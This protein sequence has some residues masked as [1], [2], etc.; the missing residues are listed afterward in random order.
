[1]SYLARLLVVV[2]GYLWSYLATCSLIWLPEVAG[3]LWSSLATVYLF[4]LF[5]L[6]IYIPFICLPSWH[7]W[8]VMFLASYLLSDLAAWGSWL[9]V[10][11][12]GYCVLICFIPII[13]LLY[14]P[15]I[16]LPGCRTRLVVALASTCCSIWLPFFLSSDLWSYLAA[17][18][19]WL[20]VVLTGYLGY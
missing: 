8:L 2:S 3:Y 5:L 10:I 7:I 17:F 9:P 12:P 14:R 11:L 19:S 4:V 16:W 13:N 20:S 18:G 15:L 6:F 1:M